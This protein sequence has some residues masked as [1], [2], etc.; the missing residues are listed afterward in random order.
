VISPLARAGFQKGFELDNIQIDSGEIRLTIN[1]DPERVISFNPKDSLFAEKFYKLVGELQEKQKEYKAR[2]EELE[3]NEEV[4]ENGLPKNAPELLALVTESCQYM[5]EQID[6][7]FGKGTSD[8]AFGGA[9][10]LEMF[11]QFFDG[12]GPFIGKARA[13]KINQY[14]NKRPRRK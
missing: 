3:S 8:T 7:L 10:T 4:D 5:R 2:A 13:E 1:H 6:H 11:V 12:V 14:T 9:N